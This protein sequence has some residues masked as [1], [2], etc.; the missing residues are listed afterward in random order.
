MR[1]AFV[2]VHAPAHALARAVD[3]P[4]QLRHDL[5]RRPPAA[6]V[7]AVIAVGGD[8]RILLR[9]SG[10]HADA[11][12]L[13]AVV[14]MAE[15]ADELALVEDVRRNL[16]APHEV[17]L[18]EHI[19]DLRLR[20][21]H[22]LRGGLDVVRLEGHRDLDG[23]R[24]VAAGGRLLGESALLSSKDRSGRVGQR[25]DRRRSREGAAA[26]GLRRVTKVQDDDFKLP[27]RARSRL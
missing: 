4:H 26:G 25:D 16:E 27:G 17:R 22:H 19:D 2:H 9:E 8:D 13:L 14:Q 20:S 21:F 1:V 3:P 7:R 6:E 10:F 11:H 5:Q 24:I 15:P 23:H 18:G 12:G